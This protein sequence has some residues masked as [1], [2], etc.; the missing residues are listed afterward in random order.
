MI[1]GGR[2]LLQPH[3]MAMRRREFGYKLGTDNSQYADLDAIR[4]LPSVEEHSGERHL[5]YFHGGNCALSFK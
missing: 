5:C 4:Y 2:Q 1:S 3:A